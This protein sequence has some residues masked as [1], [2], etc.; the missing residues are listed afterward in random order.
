MGQENLIAPHILSDFSYGIALAARTGVEPI[1]D[2]SRCC[3]VRHKYALGCALREKM[4][5]SQFGR[6]AQN[7]APVVSEFVRKKAS[8]F[9]ASSFSLMRWVSAP[10]TRTRLTVWQSQLS[11]GRLLGDRSLGGRGVLW[12]RYGSVGTPRKCCRREHARFERPCLGR[13]VG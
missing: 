13:R 6:I 5:I 1:F 10:R 9:L 8:P 7:N 11:G 4:Q 2:V 12:L 3:A